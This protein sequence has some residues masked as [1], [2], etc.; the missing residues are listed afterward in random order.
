D[1]QVIH[2]Q[3]IEARYIRTV[4]RVNNEN[5]LQD[6]GKIELIFHPDYE[7]MIV[8][9]LAIYRNG[10]VINVLDN[11]SFEILRQEKELENQIYLGTKTA[12]LVIQDL[13]VGDYLDLQFTRYGANPIF[14]GHLFE[15]FQMNWSMPIKYLNLSIKTAK[16][17]LIK[18]KTSDQ[19]LKYKKST[20][21]NTS[22]YHWYLEDIAAVDIQGQTPY[23]FMPY[24]MVEVSDF[25]DWSAVVAWAQSVFTVEKSTT[26]ELDQLVEAWSKLPT[27]TEQVSAALDFV[28]NQIRYFGIEIGVNS[29]K[30]RLVKDTFSTKFGDC[31]D[32]TILLQTILQRLNI[33][34]TPAL[35]STSYH[36]G[37]NNMLPS[38]GVFDHV[39]LKVPLNNKNYWLDSTIS[40]QGGDINTIGE[41]PYGAALPIEHTVSAL[42][43]IK[44]NHPHIEKKHVIEQFD[45][46]D[47]NQTKLSTQTTYY[48]F[49]ATRIRHRL[50][51]Q[52]HND[53]QK[54][55]ESYV[56]KL[57]GRAELSQDVTFKDNLDSNLFSHHELY[58]IS[59]MWEQK[60]QYIYSDIIIWGLLN[61]L[62]IPSRVIRNTP[63][64]LPYPLN[65]NHEVK[66]IGTGP[67]FQTDEKDLIINSDYLNFERKV[68]K[69]QGDL[70]ISFQLATR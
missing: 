44:F 46:S 21:K 4:Q 43:P 12:L 29:H 9:S 63:L 2:H 3:D 19:N 56:N 17:K 25:A 8:N 36:E 60:G 67:D 37:I 31:K 50:I 45:F 41:V 47:N 49:E 10:Q 32:K 20:E 39:I 35:V 54:Q 57:Y 13:R 58:N 15:Q 34:S 53:L 59:N 5:A 68:I 22:R 61:Y 70:Q 51:N 6:I 64:A 24:Q 42:E 62:D 52:T 33:P 27:Q 65:L 30:P 1:R 16:D 48:G 28:Q 11:Q 7:Q 69:T 14:D 18:I 66:L 55:F 23:W 38:P 26:K 40:N